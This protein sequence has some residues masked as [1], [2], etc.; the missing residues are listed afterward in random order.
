MI[1]KN[2][3]HA[4]G[5]NDLDEVVFDGLTGEAYVDE[6]LVCQN[7]WRKNDYVTSW[8]P[9]DCFTRPAADACRLR[10]GAGNGETAR[11]MVQRAP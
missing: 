10:S 2:L 1:E 11:A 8:G 4:S 5:C 7:T 9:T 6:G 3:A